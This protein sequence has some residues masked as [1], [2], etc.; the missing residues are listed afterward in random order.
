MGDFEVLGE[1]FIG[2]GGE[3]Q[4]LG[5]IVF[6]VGSDEVGFPV[7]DAIE[8]GFGEGFDDFIIVGCHAGIAEEPVV[9]AVRG[10]GREC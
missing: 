3:L 4:E 9:D 2:G 10:A 5:K 1:E 6:F 8:V 7:L